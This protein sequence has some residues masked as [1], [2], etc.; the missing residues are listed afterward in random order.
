ML[1]QT[2]FVIYYYVLI[3]VFLMTKNW[4]DY[5][6]HNRNMIPLVEKKIG[7]ESKIGRYQCTLQNCAAESQLH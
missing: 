2:R 1:F 3:Y 6:Y 5:E 4:C 7:R